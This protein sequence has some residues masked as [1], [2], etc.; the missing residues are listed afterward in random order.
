M[1]DNNSE[2]SGDTKKDLLNAALELFALNGYKGVS[3]RQIVEKAKVNISAIT[4]YFGG[5]DGLYKAVIES[6]VEFFE[7]KMGLVL[8]EIAANKENDIENQKKILLKFIDKYINFLFSKGVSQY[9]VLLLIREMNSPS[10]NFDFFYTRV[11]GRV[12]KS[13]TQLLAAI[14]AKPE[15]D[16][17]MILLTATLIG[18]ILIFRLGK[19]VILKRLEREDYDIELLHKMKQTILSNIKIIINNWRPL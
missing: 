3:T 10:S 13:L 2:V 1:I 17:E 18:Q 5:K 11:I 6:K 12:H 9:A 15:D 16:D 19:R 4:Y 14:F 8:D 7:S